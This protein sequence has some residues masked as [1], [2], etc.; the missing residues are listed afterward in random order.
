MEYSLK[1]NVAVISIDDGKA[2]VVDHRFVDNMTALL[3][4]AG[5]EAG[6]VLLQAR[7]GMFSAGFDLKELQKGRREAEALV[8]RGME[9]LTQIYAFPRPVVAACDGHAVGLGAFMLLAADFRLGS[10][11]DYN[12]TLPET[13]IGMPFTP[14]L[15]TLIRDRIA[16]TQQ[17][18]AVLQ[19]RPY[20]AEEAREAGFLDKVTAQD[21]L[22][23]E[24]Q[25]LAEQLSQLPGEAYA[26]NKEDLRSH[27]LGAMRES[28]G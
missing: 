14:V 25:A 17:T 2:N 5:E 20:R 4:R 26:A 19:S 3:E 9:L 16:S 10:A 22:L 13:A 27:A 18:L 8:A 6:A 24:C 23:S 15:M 11:T 7:A 1:N 28:I 12:I 21:T